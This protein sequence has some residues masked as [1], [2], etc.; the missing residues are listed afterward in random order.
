[1]HGAGDFDRRIQFFTASVSE[2]D[3]GIEQETLAAGHVAWARVSFGNGAERREAAGAG[4]VQS[5]IFR[6]LASSATRAITR[7]DV[8]RFDGCDWGIS[9]ISPVGPQGSEIEFVATVRKG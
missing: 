1:M 2:D 3:L 8:I 7:R 4:G 9:S 6:V 5:A